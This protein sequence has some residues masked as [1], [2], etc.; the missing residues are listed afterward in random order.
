MCGIA[1]I[2]NY[3]NQDK[4]TL[5]RAEIMCARLYH[6]GPDGQNI[7]TLTNATLVH[8]RLALIDLDGGSQPLTSAD[9]RYSITYNGEIYNYQSL[10]AELESHWLF[11]TESDTEVVL[12]SYAI[13]GERCTAKFNGMFAFF[14]WD[15][16]KQEGF[17]ARDLL[18]VKP[19]VYRYNS[20]ELIFSSEAKAIVAVLES[21]PIANQ[22]AIVE[23]LVSPYFSGVE[24]PM[25]EGLKYL[26]PGHFLKVTPK[27]IQTHQWQ[28]YDLSC[29]TI[30]SKDSIEDMSNHLV[31]A[32][33]NT[34]IADVPIST[35]LSGGFDSTLITSIANE[36]AAGGGINTFTVQFSDQDKFKYDDSL[37]INSNDTPCAADAARTIGVHQ[38][39]VNVNRSDIADSIKGISISN[40]G[41]PAWEQEIAQHHL[42][43]AA[44]KKYKATLVGD[45]ADETHYG[46]PFLLDQHATQSPSGIIQ[47]FSMPPAYSRVIPDPLNHF[48]EKYR[49]LTIQAG[50]NWDTPVDRYLATTYLIVKRWLPRLLHNG[51]IHAMRHSL[52]TR[53]PFA[54]INLLKLAKTISPLSGYRN[55]TEK[56]LLRESAKGLM[57]ERARLRKKSALPKD[58]RTATIYKNIGRDLFVASYGF[59]SHFLDMKKIDTLCKPSHALCEQDRSLLFRVISLCYWHN[60]YGVNIR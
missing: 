56:W 32:V 36:H 4:N 18:G 17:A 39:I 33:K 25:F 59:L 34:M 22:E 26:H 49:A 14:V 15:S 12:A 27:G 44:S 52:E 55:G 1:G 16:L 9:Q 13:W 48:D 24:T 29:S 20:E 47:R 53:V 51:D 11:A 45:A 19:F 31:D 57:P 23:Y 5:H 40:D 21:D 8:T 28:D 46:Y 50:Y 38:N 2:I 7:I 60:A 6:R 54:D 43:L 3:R 30:A 42:G 58:Q 41:L 37:I 10:R 35:Y